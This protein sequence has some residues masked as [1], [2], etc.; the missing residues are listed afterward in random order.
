MHVP[1]AAGRPTVLAL[2]GRGGREDD[3]VSLVRAAGEGLGVLAPRGPEPEGMGYAWFRNRGIGV[4]VMD[5]LERCLGVVAGFL[6][7]A[8]AAHGLAAPL[9][10]VGLSNGGMMAGAL[11]AAHGELVG[12]V[13]L[14]SS[15]YPLP[16]EVYTRGGLAGRRV[17]AAGGAADPFLPLPVARAG[18]AGYR[19]AGAE[20]TE[21]LHDGGHEVTPDEL[22]ALAAWLGTAPP[23]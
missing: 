22:A 3:L 16:A 17:L 23:R 2:H 10:A 8:V 9:T 14:L 6:E 5:S 1:A 12:D 15:A 13:A 4:P 20:V 11:S 18:V 19:S 7:E 21:Y